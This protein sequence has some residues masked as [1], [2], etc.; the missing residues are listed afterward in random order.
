MYVNHCWQLTV[1]RNQK[2]EFRE[3]QI[4][5]PSNVKYTYRRISCDTSL[6]QHTSVSTYSV[7]P[8]R[9][10]SHPHWAVWHHHSEKRR[11][12]QSRQQSPGASRNYPYRSA[13]EKF[14]RRCRG[15]RRCRS[16]SRNVYSI[17]ACSDWAIS[18]VHWHKRC[19]IAVTETLCEAR[20]FLDK[21]QNEAFVTTSLT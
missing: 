17:P 21:K 5:V 18:C 13:R 16:R 2:N 14:T 15:R 11:R 10:G 12:V 9:E 8:M 7:E 1:N 3:Q 19:Y 4:D 20:V 6:T